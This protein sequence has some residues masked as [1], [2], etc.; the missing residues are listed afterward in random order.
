MT[1][2]WPFA[3]LNTVVIVFSCNF[4]ILLLTKFRFF[5][6]N[7][8]K[9]WP[10]QK[11]AQQANFSAIPEL[12]SFCTEY[13]NIVKFKAINSA[14][15]PNVKYFMQPYLLWLRKDSAD[16]SPLPLLEIT[17]KSIHFLLAMK[18]IPILCIQFQT[19]KNDKGLKTLHLNTDGQKINALFFLKTNNSNS[20]LTGI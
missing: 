17:T 19:N 11:L 20:R 15:W 12:C 7:K 13:K 5:E 10:V 18:K 4:I 6:R 14:C 16:V 3:F 1:T 9:V 8:Q 2:K